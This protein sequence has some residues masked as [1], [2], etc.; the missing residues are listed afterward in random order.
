MV[1]RPERPEEVAICDLFY[2]SPEFVRN[3]AAAPWDAAALP[4][5]DAVGSQRG[6][7]DHY[8]MQQRVVA[9]HLH[10]AVAVGVAG[11]AEAARQHDDDPEIRRAAPEG[12]PVT[13]AA[14]ALGGKK[15]GIAREEAGSRWL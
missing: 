3:F 5:A 7:G 8:C 13:W 2:S 12:H 10:R 9:G 6:L 15:V 1:G 4:R 14:D 11:A